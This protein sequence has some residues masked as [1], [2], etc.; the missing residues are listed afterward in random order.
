HPD[1]PRRLGDGAAGL[2]RGGV[3]GGR[4]PAARPGK[5]DRLMADAG[6]DTFLVLNAGSSSIKFSLFVE[7]DGHLALVTGGQVSGIYTAP[8]FVAKDAAGKTLGEARWESPA[9]LGHDG[10]LAHIVDW[11][12]RQYARDHRL[13]AVG[14]RIVHGGSFFV[15]PTRIDAGVVAK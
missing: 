13:V 4:G 6:A 10:A 7:R 11:I 2:L 14:H 1:Q 12:R 5:G 8:A 9:G 3:A 15:A